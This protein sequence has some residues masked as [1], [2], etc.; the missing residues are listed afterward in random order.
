MKTLR[1]LCVVAVLTLLGASRGSDLQPYEVRVY[2]TIRKIDAS[3]RLVVIAY[4]PLDTAPGGIR[5]MRVRT[6]D[7]LRFLERGD[8]VSAIA[9]PR[10]SP[11]V[12]RDLH[13]MQ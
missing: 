4:A 1:A 11:W 13:R 2:G 9:D 7:H 12:V 3:H 5:T 10:R 8:P 6:T